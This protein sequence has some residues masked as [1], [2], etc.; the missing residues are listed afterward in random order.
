MRDHSGYIE[1]E[2]H[3]AMGD[4]LRAWEFTRETEVLALVTSVCFVPN[5]AVASIKVATPSSF[6]R[7]RLT[8][9][10]F[11]SIHLLS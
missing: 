6:F 8:F 11:T 10:I 2:R 7:N 5:N 9:F 4:I 3:E 1:K